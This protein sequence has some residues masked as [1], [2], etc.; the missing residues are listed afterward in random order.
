[1]KNSSTFFPYIVER[2]GK[3]QDGLEEKASG[4]VKPRC[5]LQRL[6]VEQSGQGNLTCVSNAEFTGVN[7]VL[8]DHLGF[9][10]DAR[11]ID[12]SCKNNWPGLDDTL[13]HFGVTVV[14]IPGVVYWLDDENNR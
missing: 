4:M 1:M 3:S 11:Q 9:G 8:I 5:N 12:G 10:V 7:P 2:Y 13:R 6:K 14:T